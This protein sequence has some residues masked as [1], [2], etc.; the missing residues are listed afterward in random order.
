MFILAVCIMMMGSPLFEKKNMIIFVVGADL[1]QTSTGEKG[2]DQTE[3]KNSTSIMI[4]ENPHKETQELA[5]GNPIQFTTHERWQLRPFFFS[6][7]SHG[8]T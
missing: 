2:N 4:G 7:P 6:S 3:K 8:I 1:N 5:L